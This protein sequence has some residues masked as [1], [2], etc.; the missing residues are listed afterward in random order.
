MY[1]RIVVHRRVCVSVC[2][3]YLC[4]PACQFGI[5]LWEN[6]ISTV[7]A[8]LTSWRQGPKRDCIDYRLCLPIGSHLLH[9]GPP[10]VANAFVVVFDDL[11]PCLHS[12]A[13]F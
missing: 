4:A 5:K 3:Y 8:S 1:A 9:S 12:Y 2:L 10:Q 13:K 7:F 6:E 11:S